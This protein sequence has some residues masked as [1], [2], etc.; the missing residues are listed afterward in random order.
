MTAFKSTNKSASAVNLLLKKFYVRLKIFLPPNTMIFIPLAI[1][2][3]SSGA[4]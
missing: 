1:G 4:N 2:E 3:V